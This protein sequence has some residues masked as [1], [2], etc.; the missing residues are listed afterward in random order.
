MT[1][2]QSVYEH[3]S[4]IC[5]PF[6][7]L[8]THINSL[9]WRR[10]NDDDI[11]PWRFWKS[12]NPQPIEFVKHTS[13]L[14]FL[15]TFFGLRVKQKL[16]IVWNFMADSRNWFYFRCHVLWLVADAMYRIAISNSIIIL[17]RR[18][19]AKETLEGLLPRIYFVH[20]KLVVYCLCCYQ[21]QSCRHEPKSSDERGQSSK[22]W[23][24]Q[25]CE[26]YFLEFLNNIFLHFAYLFVNS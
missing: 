26:E 6:F 12:L 3:T 19:R 24:N 10:T 2:V 1:K 13:P 23:D 4:L 14:T 7:L 20:T 8:F 15:I 18:H 9:E 11:Q 17:D 16:F 5:F 21:E 22:Q 25:I